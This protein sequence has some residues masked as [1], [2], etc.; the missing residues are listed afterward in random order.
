VL[1]EAATGCYP[2]D[3]TG[4]PVELMIQAG[5]GWR[6]EGG[7]WPGG[8]AT[9]ASVMW[10]PQTPH[11]APPG[12]CS[13]NACHTLN[14]QLAQA[15]SA[16]AAQAAAPSQPSAAPLFQQI[17]HDE[18]PLPAPGSVSGA[19]RDF[20]RCCL[21]TDP[22]RRPSAEQL[23]SHPFVT[24]AAAGAAP[25][26]PQQQP[27]QH[28]PEVAAELRRFMAVMADPLEKW[29]AGGGTRGEG[30]RW[31]ASSRWPA[32]AACWLAPPSAP[33]RAPASSGAS[34]RAR[35]PTP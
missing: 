16:A 13:W 28:T 23:L 26:P 15:E 1:V 10:R 12:P 17:L 33:H 24:G 32:E 4:G 22:K 3:A 20:V 29:V 6:G 11:L 35:R 5:R 8:R 25:P 30:P 19:L 14:Q 18:P 34:A 21:A 7:C 9:L 2:Y 27:Q 31:P